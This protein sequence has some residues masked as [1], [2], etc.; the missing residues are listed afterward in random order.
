MTPN[1]LHFFWYAKSKNDNSLFKLPSAVNKIVNL[2]D[3]PLKDILV[4]VINSTVKPDLD[5]ATL[6]TS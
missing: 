1:R 3:E 6:L 2:P 4:T 5:C